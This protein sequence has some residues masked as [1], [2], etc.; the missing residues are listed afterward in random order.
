MTYAATFLVELGAHNGVE[1]IT[2]RYSGGGFVTGPADE[3]PNAEYD[4]RIARLDPYEVHLFGQGRTM[5]E[6]S[7]APGA[8]E[9]ANPDGAL[10]GLKV[11]GFDGRPFTL[12]R[13]ATPWAP[14]ASAETVLTGTLEGLDSETG[15]TSLRLRFYDRRRD[16]DKP[17]QTTTY[18]GTTNSADDG[19]ADGN[20]DQKGLLKPVLYGVNFGV[21]GI[22]VDAFHLIIQ[23]NDGPVHHIDAKDG[24]IPL[25]FDADY[26]DL[27]ALTAATGRPG[28][29]ATC[30]ALGLWRPFGAFSKRP[31]FVWTADVAEGATAAD[32]RAGAIMTRMLVRMG[33]SG[34][35]NI[36]AASLAALDAVATAEHGFYSE[37]EV[38]GL[39]AVRQVLGSVGAS[40]VPD[41]FGRFT[42]VRLDMPGVPV[43]E[44]VEPDI[45][46]SATGLSFIRNPDTD[47]NAPAHRIN[48]R[49]APMRHVHSNAE[50]GPSFA[51]A[52]PIAAERLKQEWREV[53]AENAAVLDKHLLS[54]PL[55]IETTFA[56][57]ADAQAEADRQ[58]VLYGVDREAVTV[59]AAKEDAG[60]MVLGATIT[61]RHS[62]LGYAGG[63]DMVVIG[64][65]DDWAGQTVAL[66]LWG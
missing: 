8:L 20:E 52:D 31:G 23:V 45:L 34:P 7:V 44:L 51:D 27:A 26:P 29:Y 61:L 59:G 60:A 11:Y 40:P 3:P 4:A 16:L 49:F 46:G 35:D 58:L 12:K 5:G 48:L 65:S 64:R 37:N 47:G 66:T 54:R 57:E 30:L 1:P 36:D 42:A 33:L 28:H 24:G 38:S 2:L 55:D 19:G 10:D 41:R 15:L 13:L 17:L 18:G 14:Y 62:R 50:V 25:V 56:L 21:P 63:K 22:L 32:R 39:T 53:S 9:L 43:A 6:L